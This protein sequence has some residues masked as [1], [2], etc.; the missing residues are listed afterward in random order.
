MIAHHPPSVS[1]IIPNLHSPLIGEVVAAVRQQ[2]AAARIADVLVVGQDRFGRIPRGVTSIETQR[3]VSAAA[4]RNLGARYARGDYL[5]FLDAD[6]IAAPDLVER[7]LERH[8]EGRAVV[9]GGVVIAPGGYWTDCDNLLIF[10]PFLSEA[11]AGLRAELPSLNLGIERALFTAFG[12]FDER[13]AGAAGEDTDLCLRLRAAGHELFFAPEAR[14]THRPARSSARAVWNHLRAYGRAYY[15]VQRQ[16]PTLAASPLAHLPRALAGAVLA[17]APLLAL[18]DAVRLAATHP[19]IRRR[20]GLLPGI[21][22]AKSGWYWGAV[23]ARL[24]HSAGAG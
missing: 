21:A 4:A 10:A 19:T 16:H 12:G 17:A 23:E 3:P 22:W 1:V 15:R 5:L 2:T 18:T 9:G 7:L 6:C 24:A 8:A 13:F 11:P 14:V 20:P